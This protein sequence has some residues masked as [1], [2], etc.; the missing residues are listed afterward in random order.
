M[1]IGKTIISGDTLIK[2]W[3]LLVHSK[4]L[5]LT[6]AYL[7]EKF[8][9]SPASQAAGERRTDVLL[10]PSSEATPNRI[11]LI[12]IWWDVGSIFCCPD[13]VTKWIKTGQHRLKPS[14]V[15][16]SQNGQIITHQG[17]FWAALMILYRVQTNMISIRLATLRCKFVSL[18]KLVLSSSRQL[19]TTRQSWQT[20]LHATRPA[21]N[22]KTD[23]VSS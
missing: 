22:A 11:S 19:L 14:A 3:N 20:R 6:T 1:K 4:E 8:L 21:Q 18:I 5:N 7:G 12:E 9:A 13:H 2:K 15:I 17:F 10:N 16:V 23:D